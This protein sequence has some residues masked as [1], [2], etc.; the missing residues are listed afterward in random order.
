MKNQ[1]AWTG[2]IL[3]LFLIVSQVSSQRAPAP[4]ANAE[5][6][7]WEYKYFNPTYSRGNQTQ[8]LNIAEMN[9]LGA[10]GWE[11]AGY[12]PSGHDSSEAFIFT[13][14]K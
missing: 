10:E 5:N 4:A 14:K 7:T 11:L 1:L 12:H 8:P 9:K 3:L 13:R 6:Y 2:W